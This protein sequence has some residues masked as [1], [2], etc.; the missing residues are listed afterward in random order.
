M[1]FKILPAL[2]LSGLM[3][4]SVFANEVNIPADRDTTLIEDARGDLANGSGPSFFVGRTNQAAFGIRRG[5]IRFDV[6]AAL[7]GNASIDRV[8]LR[9]YQTSSNPEPGAISLHRVLA[10]WGEGKSFKDG[11]RGAPAEADDAT[12]LYTFYDQ[13]HWTHAGGHYVPAASA[14]AVVNGRDFRSWQSTDKLVND[15]RLWLHAPQQN[16]GWLL[17]GDEDS[18]GSVKRF[19]SHEAPATDQHPML[20]IE[21]HLPGK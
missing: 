2:L 14:T 12:W 6:A 8:S 17:T 9:L 20:T 7:P 1:M 11:G 3:A 10:D 16:Y 15:V 5:L 13:G 21:Y 18:R 19:A 4:A